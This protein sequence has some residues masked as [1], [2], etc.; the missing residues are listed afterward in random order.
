M[1]TLTGFIKK[2][3]CA[4]E[5]EKINYAFTGALA[6]S[7][8]GVPRTTADIDII[9]SMSRKDAKTKLATALRSTGLEVEEKTIDDAY[10]SGFCIATFKGKTLP[11]RVDIIFAD[12]LRKRQG[13]IA[14]IGTWLQAPEDLVN[15]K[16]RMIKVTLDNN[17]TAKD[18]SDI[19]AILQFTEVDKR[20]INEQAKK[21]RTLQ[22]WKRL[23]PS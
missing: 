19:R 8:Y 2:I 16:L 12:T 4:L 10:T 18:E 17:K 9:L 21:D 20:L 23:K 11:Y 14:D 7:Y 15:A 5:V 13:N 6:A 1:E 3:V 22:V